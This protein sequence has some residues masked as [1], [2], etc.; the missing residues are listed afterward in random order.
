VNILLDTNIILNLIRADNYGGLMRFIN[1]E[2]ARIYVSVA[3]EAE[4]RSL[5]IRKKWGP[6]KIDFLEE[7]LSRINIVDINRFFIST[8]AQIDAYS[9]CQNSD[10]DSYPF[11]TPRNMGKND[12]W[13]ASVAALLS[14]ELVTTDSDFDH[15]D[16]VFLDLRKIHPRSFYRF[17]K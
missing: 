16:K 10:F 17:S 14:L 5:A 3:S 12:L 13:I 2:N 8:Y 1:P 4:I 6:I 11:K 7:F 15:L 9:Q